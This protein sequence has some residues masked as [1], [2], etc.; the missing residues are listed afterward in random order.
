[1]T[2]PARDLVGY[3]PAP[4]H[5]AWPTGARLAINV[6][7]NY[8]EGS[9]RSPLEGDRD[10]EPLTDSRYDIPAGERDLYMESSYEYGSRVGV[11][12]LLRLLDEIGIRPTVF[13]CGLAF[14]RNPAAVAAFVER[15]CDFV[16]H[17]YRWIP[18]LGL[19][20]EEQAADIRR[21]VDVLE[22]MT[23][24]RVL[25]WFGRAPNTVH[26]RGLLA[27]AGLLYDSGAV[28][29]DLPYFTDVGGRPFLVVPYSLDVNDVRFWK[30]ELATGDQFETYVRDSFDR[31]RG[32]PED[33]DHR[34]P[35][36][37]HRAPGPPRR[38]PPGARAHPPARRTL[39][40]G[41]RRHR[42][43]VGR[44]VRPRRHVEPNLS[45]IAVARR[46]ASSRRSLVI[47]P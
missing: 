7:L 9:E 45:A 36:A 11:W 25:G 3:G 8:E 46:A 38:P 23:G 35:S 20:V 17:G 31:E 41:A 12:R 14:E 21:C 2:G 10:L 30:G 6:A 22:R 47:V 1:V 15:G 24:R 43:R 34:P 26:T 16:G 37:D 27:E 39:V 5:V 19:T 13:G 28:N 40:R 44:P 4:P 32:G 29:D 18:H 33:D 42:P